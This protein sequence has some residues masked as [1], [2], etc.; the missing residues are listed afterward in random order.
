[1]KITFGKFAT[2]I[3]LSAASQVAPGTTLVDDL[4][5]VS[6]TDAQRAMATPIGTACPTG[7]APGVPGASPSSMGVLLSRDF[8][9][10]CTEVVVATLSSSPSGPSGPSSPSSSSLASEA[11]A[12]L[13]GMAPEEGAVLATSQVDAGE[14]QMNNIGDRLSS[15]HGGGGATGL[16]YRNNSGFNWSSGAAGDGASPWGFFINGLYVTSDR[17]ST[18]R[19]SGFEAD[20][21]GVTGGI[22][23]TFSDKFIFG[24]AFGYKNSD[25]D[26]DAN[27]GTLETDSNSY[28]AYW[29]LYPDDRWYVDAMVG[30]T[31]NDHDQDRGINYTI[32]G[33]GATA[34]TTVVVSNTAVSET[35]SDE[36]SVSVAAGY[37][38]YS[39]TWTLS[40]YGRIEYADID[41]DGFTE[42]MA[43]TGANGS[44]L[45][46]QI[47]DQDFESLMLTFGGRAT[48]QWGERFFPE[49]SVEYVHEFKNSNSPTTGRFVDDASGTT[50]VLLTDPPDRNFVN[51]GAGM[52]AVVSDQLSGFFRYQGLVGYKDLSV[53]A[54]EVGLRL[55]F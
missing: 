32:A 13:Q 3:M 47:D 34:G 50:F 42:Q 9:D 19:E 28:F 8:R 20:D 11:Q 33:A 25:A 53:H 36:I 35:D 7:L 6:G 15:F 21:F 17:D 24:V 18:S 40:P 22:D 14:T 12:G 27:G 4:E 39:G 49:V 55:S 46:L 26:I 2:I 43:L 38:F 1:M 45:A 29:S 52:S 51:I 10:R 31:D 5:S 23:Y 54:F 44:G 37:N 41:V 30:Y 16:V 48:A